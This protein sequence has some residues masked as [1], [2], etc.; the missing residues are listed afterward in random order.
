MGRCLSMEFTILEV[1]TGAED[2]VKDV[3]ELFRGP[4][5][6]N[7]GSEVKGTRKLFPSV[8]KGQ[9]LIELLTLTYALVEE[10][11]C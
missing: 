9:R 7:R 10:R 4:T 5:S 11:C 8:R 3:T 1:M 2:G 6:I